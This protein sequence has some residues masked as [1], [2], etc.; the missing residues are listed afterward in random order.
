MSCMFLRY[1]TNHLMTE[2]SGVQFGMKSNAR[3]QNHSF[4]IIR[5]GGNFYTKNAKKNFF[6]FSF[7]A[8]SLDG[9]K[10]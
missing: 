2:L 3:L 10:I 5:K 9:F 4:I 1:I 8:I 7:C 6:V